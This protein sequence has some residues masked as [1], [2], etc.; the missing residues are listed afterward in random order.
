[1][2]VFNNSRL[3]SQVLV[4]HFVDRGLGY[5]SLQTETC[6]NF[7][8]DGCIPYFLLKCLIIQWTSAPKLFTSHNITR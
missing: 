1:M 2:Y 8:T 3:R 6:N 7:L 4:N 5:I